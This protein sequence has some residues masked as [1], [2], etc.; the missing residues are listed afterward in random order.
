MFKDSL[1]NTYTHIIK[2]RPEHKA[3]P[4]R[5]GKR[6]QA[7]KHKCEDY[8]RAGRREKNKVRHIEQ[9]AK[10]AT[11]E[12]RSEILASEKVKVRQA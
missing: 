7:H 12:R 1:G 2:G 4:T 8:A 9:D 10:R 3:K 5:H 6:T 11:P